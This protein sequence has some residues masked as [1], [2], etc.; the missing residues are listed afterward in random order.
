MNLSPINHAHQ[1]RF[2]KIIISDATGRPGHYSMDVTLTDEDRALKPFPSLPD[3]FRIIQNPTR[4]GIDTLRGLSHLPGLSSVRDYLPE[5]AID[6]DTTDKVDIRWQSDPHGSY[7]KVKTLASKDRGLLAPLVAKMSQRNA[8][9]NQA[10]ASSLASL[11]GLD[12]ELGDT[13]P[14]VTQVAEEMARYPNVTYGPLDHKG[15]Q[16]YPQYYRSLQQAM[17]TLVNWVKG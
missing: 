8:E 14:Y 16:F 1:P 6:E 17:E 2:G 11:N 15:H 5:D 10:I 7:D 3:H 9:A 12:P 13:T 4:I